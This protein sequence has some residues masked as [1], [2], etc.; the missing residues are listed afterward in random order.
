MPHQHP[1]PITTN[2]AAVAGSDLCATCASFGLRRAFKHAEETDDRKG[3]GGP[4]GWFTLGLGVTSQQLKASECSLC[5]LFA[6]VSPPE[7]SNSSEAMGAA[8]CH[9][10]A[11]PTW[12]ALMG[13]KK[14]ACEFMALSC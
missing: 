8:Q 1:G 14:P 3:L 10:L 7:S 4:I 2:S 12:A 6:S 5:Q 9:V 13:F 11:V